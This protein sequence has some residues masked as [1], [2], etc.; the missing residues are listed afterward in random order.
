[1]GAWLLL[2]NIEFSLNFA[3]FTEF[4]DKTNEYKA[5]RIFDPAV[6]FD[7]LLR[8]HYVTYVTYVE[9]IFKLTLIQESLISSDVLEKNHTQTIN[10]ESLLRRWEMFQKE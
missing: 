7:V 5:K 10:L 1:M 3:E 8:R 2:P 6:S 9:R 4:S